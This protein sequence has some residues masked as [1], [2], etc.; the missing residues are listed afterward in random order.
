MIK[1]YLYLVEVNKILQEFLT[2]QIIAGGSDQFISE[3][4]KQ[5]LTNQSET[6]THERFIDYLKKLK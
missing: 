2:S 3:S 1:R 6:K 4:R 5:L